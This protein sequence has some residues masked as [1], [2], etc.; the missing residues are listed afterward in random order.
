MRCVRESTYM[1]YMSGSPGA[2]NH[3]AFKA[4]P[5]MAGGRGIYRR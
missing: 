2:A 4:V 1:V 5:P 3:V